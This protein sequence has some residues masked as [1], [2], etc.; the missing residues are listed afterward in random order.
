MVFRRKVLKMLSGMPLGGWLVGGVSDAVRADGIVSAEAIAVAKVPPKQKPEKSIYASLGVRPLI[1]ARGTV[2]ILGATR[3]LPEVQ[4][5]MDEA[6]REYV[7]LDELMDGVAHRLAAL[8]GAEWGIV[9]SGASAALTV[10]TAGCV[11]GGDPDKLWQIPTLSGMKDEVII[12]AYSRT[13]YDA[14]ARAVG[15]R[16]TEVATLRELEAALGPRTAMIMVLAGSRSAHGPLSLTEIAALAKPRGIPI[17]VDAA[18]EGW[19]YPT[20]TWPKGRI[21]SLTAEENTC[22][23]PSVPAC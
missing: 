21:W 18:A 19:K 10:A 20:H 17:L 13:A 23:V 8:T 12:P 4:Q 16:M 11:S 15:V 5:A 9:T 7:P 2:T 14:A 1:N 3:M 6:V 22:A